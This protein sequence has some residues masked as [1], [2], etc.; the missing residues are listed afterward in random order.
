MNGS[1]GIRMSIFLDTHIL[2]WLHDIELN[3]LS[4]VARRAI[5]SEALLYSPIVKLELVYLRASKKLG[6]EIEAFF[7]KLENALNLHMSHSPFADLCQEAESITWT[8]DLFDRLI[9][10]EATLHHAPLVTADRD[11]RQHYKK[12]LW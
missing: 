9:V 2:Y 3:K 7:F 8:R 6:V 12:A 4:K 5:E 1:H 10:A 11:I